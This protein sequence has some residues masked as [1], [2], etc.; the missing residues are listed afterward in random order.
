MKDRLMKAGT[1]QKRTALKSKA[2]KKMGMDI[3]MEG[4][5]GPT[6]SAVGKAAKKMGKYSKKG[7]GLNPSYK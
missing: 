1:K 7:T 6:M 2:S 3:A 5:G 4:M